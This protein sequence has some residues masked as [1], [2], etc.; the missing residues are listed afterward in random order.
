VV[1]PN[2]YGE[3][4]LEGPCELCEG[5]GYVLLGR[6]TINNIVPI[7]ADPDSV[8]QAACVSVDDDGT[9]WFWREGEN[10]EYAEHMVTGVTEADIGKHAAIIDWD[11]LIP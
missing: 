9:T 2:Q 3:P 7:V 11:T 10:D 8:G 4:E 5:N 1:Y 6:V